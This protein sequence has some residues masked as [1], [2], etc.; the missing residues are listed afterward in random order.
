MQ[1][2]PSAIKSWKVSFI[3]VWKVKGLFIRPKNMTRGSKIPWLVQKAAFHSSPFFILTLLY[4]HHTS[5]LVKYCTPRSW[6]SRSEI[7]GN[8]Y[9]FF[10]GY[11]VKFPIVLNWM[12][13]PILLFDKEGGSHRRLRRVNLSRC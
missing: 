1:T 13:L 12:W 3:T 6:F 2:T 7:R 8:G 11:F 4:P 10:D 9:A 5:S